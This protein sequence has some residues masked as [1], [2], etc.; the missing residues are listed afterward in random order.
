MLG[1]S[2]LMAQSSEDGMRFGSKGRGTAA[3][4]LAAVLLSLWSSCASEVDVEQLFIRSNSND[5]E[6]RVEARK[7]LA[8]LVD[9]GEV[10]PFARG[11]KSK[12]NETRVQSI[13]HLYIIRN[14]ESKKPLVD[15][16][17]ISRR[18][19]VFYNPI[20]L[21]PASTPV[22]SRIMIAHIL[23]SKGGDPRAVEI[24][25]RTY[26]QEPD[27]AARK[28][29]VYALGA[30]QDSSAIPA[31]QKA[32]RDEEAEVVRAALEG[33]NQQ[34][35]PG[36]SAVLLKGLSEPDERIRANSAEALADF[37]DPGVGEALLHA[38]QKDSSMKVRVAA[39]GAL[40]NAWGPAS[41]SP[42]LELLRDPH[43]APEL[44]ENAI[45]ALRSL[46]AQDFGSDAP[47][48]ARWWEQNKA[49]FGTRE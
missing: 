9:K 46:T 30:L 17:E 25:A 11:L 16:L 39:L 28:A 3:V 43:A 35:A 15:E 12:N 10:Q 18:F 41:F 33:L 29:T 32:L 34:N 1:D 13:L 49:V 36:T 20:R 6:E 8:E 40:P 44:R 38:V 23:K 42:I 14:T 47:K 19:N 5:Y 31:L 37:H 48:W 2:P 22:D 7:K 26:G 45:N 24:L 21:V 27:A 4:V